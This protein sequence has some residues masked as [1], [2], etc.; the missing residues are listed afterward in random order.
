MLP[1]SAFIYLTNLTTAQITR[2]SYFTHVV[3]KI[4]LI[5]KFGTRSHHGENSGSKKNLPIH[6][7]GTRV[8]ILRAKLEITFWKQYIAKYL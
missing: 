3:A 2:Q 5:K 7:P 4:P 6:P 1:T 8:H